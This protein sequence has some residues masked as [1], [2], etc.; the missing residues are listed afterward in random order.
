MDHLGTPMILGCE[1]MEVRFETSVSLGRLQGHPGL[2]NVVGCGRREVS[3]YKRPIT[4]GWL[5]G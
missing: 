1:A 5:A 4:V 3:P 2:T